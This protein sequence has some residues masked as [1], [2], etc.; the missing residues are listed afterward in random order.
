MAKKKSS[1]DSTV[2]E[3]IASYTSSSQLNADVIWQL[4]KETDE[5]FKETD[6][7]FQ[8]TDRKFQETERMFKESDKKMERIFQEL[9]GI[10]KS[11]GEVAE[12]YFFYALASSLKV[13]KMR[14]DYISRNDYRKKKMI[15][16]EYD[17]ILWNDH[18]VM[19]VEV[20][21]NFKVE[22]VRKF[23]KEQLKKFKSLYPQHKHFKVYGAIAGM[24]FA[25][26]VVK[27]AREYGFYIL[28]QKNE[29]LSI[30]NDDD[31]EPKEIR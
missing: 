4:F 2:N 26:D 5:K 8:E 17:I 28:T 19:V 12:D 6:K 30:L 22:Q 16:A 20:K 18:K 21:Y 25:K 9:G 14:F 7:K 31:F 11:N 24:T 10:G 27:T 13:G 15:E 29:Q 1:D 23:H 3:P